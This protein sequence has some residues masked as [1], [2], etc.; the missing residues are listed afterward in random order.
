MEHCGFPV[1]PRYLEKQRFP[2]DAITDAQVTHIWTQDTVLSKQ[3]ATAAN[4]QNVVETY[5]DMIGQVDAILLARDDAETHLHFAEPFLE[6]GMPI[7]VDKPLA[8]TRKA[9]ESLI[10]L[11][12]FPGQL[13]SCSA[14]RYAPELKL[15]EKQ[16]ETIGPLRYI[17]ACVS[18]DWDKYAVHVIEPLLKL[19]PE[20]DYF[21]RSQRWTSDDRTVLH[22]EFASG[23]EAQIS[24]LGSAAS[25]LGFRVSGE[26]GWCDL[27]FSDPFRAFRAALQDFVD[28]IRARDV[29]I[30]PTAMLNVVDLIELGR[31]A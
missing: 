4:I 22:V 27:H 6:V 24:T 1:I 3:V 26:S 31:R 18:K 28:G 23:I 13:F 17:T 20:H 9:A 21:V 5:T 12:R 11:E 7:Y 2:D 16:R 30:S 19:L 29:R 8:L 10:N 15:T 14:L 25:P